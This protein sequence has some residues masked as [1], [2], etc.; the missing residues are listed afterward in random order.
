MKTEYKNIYI[1]DGIIIFSYIIT[2]MLVLLS[3]LFIVVFKCEQFNFDVYRKVYMYF[4]I[5]QFVMFSLT[6][7]HFTNEESSNMKSLIKDFIKILILALSI[8]PFILIIF[9]SGNVK[10]LNLWIPIVLEI[11]YGFSII[12]FKRV[13]SL[14]KWLKEYSKFIIHFMMFFINILSLVFLY[15]YYRYSQIVI[16]TVYDKDIPKIF[17]LNPILT[18]AGYINKEITDYTQMG[19]KP[20]IWAFVFWSI[21]SLINILTLYKFYRRKSKVHNSSVQTEV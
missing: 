1:D 7:I 9:I 19:I 5:F 11:I 4:I 12:S 17:F 18:V 14:N 3:Y 6:L 8:I 21:C 13:L 20:V 10:T 15:I 2:I 16:T